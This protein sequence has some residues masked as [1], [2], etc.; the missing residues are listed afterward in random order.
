MDS[1]IHQKIVFVIYFSEKEEIFLPVTHR[2]Q[3]AL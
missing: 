2:A 1:L 3:A